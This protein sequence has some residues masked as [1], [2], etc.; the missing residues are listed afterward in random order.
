MNFWKKLKISEHE[1]ERVKLLWSLRFL[2]QIGFIWAW[3]VVTS[4]FLE[5]FGAENLLYL[6]L[7]DAWLLLLGSI[8]AHFIFIKIRNHY[9]LLGTIWGTLLCIFMAWFYRYDGILFFTSIIF[10]KD[11][12][13]S[14]LNIG[15]Y[16]KNESLL[17]PKEAQRIMPT[18]DSAVTIGTIV[19]AVLFLISLH[20]FDL[21]TTFYFWA[22]PLFGLFLMVL[23]EFYMLK[24]IPTFKFGKEPKTA[25]EMSHIEQAI[26]EIKEIPFLKYMSFLILIEA[27]L[28]AV[29]DF[30]FLKYIQHK[31]EVVSLKFQSELLQSNLIGNSLESVGNVGHKVSEALNYEVFTHTSVA[32]QLGFLALVFGAIALITQFFLA[33]KILEKIGVIY[34][35][36][37]FFG[38]LFGCIFAFFMGGV[39]MK[40]I[41]G[42]QHGFE[43]IFESAY[44]ISFYS[45]FSKKRESVRH[46]F[47]GFIR[48]IGMILGVGMIFFVNFFTEDKMAILM[49]FLTS[50]LI[51]IAIP[52]RSHFT[53]ISRDNL[54]SKQD[55]EAKLHSIE[56]LTQKGHATSFE[57]LSK[58]LLN[59]SFHPIIREKIIQASSQINDPKIIHAYL[60]ILGRKHEPDEIKIQVLESALKLTSL[61]AYW[62]DHIFAQHHLLQVLTGIFENTKH[63]YFKKLVIM[64]IFKH[65]PQDK[66]V[67]FFLDTLSLDDEELKSVCLRS[68]GEIFKDPEIIYY[69]RQYLDNKSRKLQGCAIIALWK[70]ENR[71]KLR[72]RIDKLLIS[73]NPK[74]IV[75]AIYTI[76]EVRDYERE[77]SLLGFFDHKSEEV[78]LHTAVAM[79]KLGNQQSI[80]LL[81]HFL[82]GKDDDLA[83]KTFYML[84][85]APNILNLL[86]KEIQ[87]EV[88]QK[89]QK[90]LLAERIKDT[91][92]VNKLS[93]S[94]K[95]YLKRLF[96]LAEKYDGI[97]WLEG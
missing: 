56:V 60:K 79:A 4:M 70:F 52:M 62:Q 66:V 29:I 18:I 69:I 14:Q 21:K 22:I 32:S 33:S 85:R 53:K 67:P 23:R 46:L 63:K 90:I 30:E 28:F 5:K 55:L 78:A 20:F 47:E 68:A 86:K 50:I 77:N 9:F 12:F 27:A 64:N 35:I 87:V 72:A 13:Y 11:L 49:L 94:T 39:N 91:Q 48:P 10:A 24:S 96:Q 93:T 71:D 15:L 41:R 19:S 40:F 6:F 58:E 76:G 2:Y 37:L 25:V 74:D 42:Y 1:I 8:L 3:T 16:R 81:L 36:I 92:D 65:L 83:K 34:S 82:F 75:T 61:R 51:F 57:I 44:H 59:E 73:D 31:A 89:T 7:I 43:S 80:P 88:A 17:S 26:K 38:G 45:I 54:K 84:K 95:S 97:L